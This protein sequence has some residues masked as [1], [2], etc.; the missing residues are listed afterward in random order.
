MTIDV[1]PTPSF[2]LF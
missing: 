2:A 1:Y